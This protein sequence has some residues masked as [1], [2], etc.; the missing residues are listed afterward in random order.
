MKI[1]TIKE[2]FEKYLVMADDRIIDLV[3]ATIIGNALIPR[4][5]LWLM[6]I[7]PSSG[8]KSTFLAPAAGVPGVHFFD[9]LTE[10]TFLS[11]YKVKG[12]ETSL[13]KIIG[14]GVMCF[15]DFTSIIS[16]NPVSRGEILGQ[17][18][19]VYDGNFSKRTGTGEIT[20]KGKMG[21]L[22]ASTPDIYFHLES[23]RSMGERFVYYSLIQPTDEEIVRKQETVMMSSKEIAQTLQPMYQEFCSGIHKYVEENGVPELKMTSAQQAAV[24]RA[25]IFCVSAKATVHLDFKTSKPDAL[26][27]RPGVGRDRKM[28][29]TL[30]HTLQLMNCYEHGITDLPVE[31]WMVKLVEKCA[32]SSVSRERRK[33]LEILTAY[34]KPMS[35]SHIGYTDDFGLPKESVEKYLHVLHAVALVQKKKDGNNFVW[36]IESEETKEFIRSV[37]NL[38]PEKR[39]L[40]P[41]VEEETVEDLPS[42]LKEDNDA[43]LADFDKRP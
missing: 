19:L 40:P 5:P 32:Y 4:D 13:L 17:L 11:G 35:A 42:D 3:L 28:F 16:K 36:Y 2:E 29:N 31:D 34:D 41:M 14:S 20:W 24:H 10:K 15:S 8:G 30:L 9:D 33:I 1:A 38:S 18:R 43:L 26:V 25:A 27:N 6:I 37:A 39:E 7:A 22:G 23:S 21:F 12:K